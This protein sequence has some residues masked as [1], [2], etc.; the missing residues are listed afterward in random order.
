M[1]LSGKDRLRILQNAIA[2]V[3]SIDKVD[4]ATELAKSVSM[5]N[6]FNAQQQ[7][8]QFGSDMAMNAPQATGGMIS[9]DASQG[10]TEEQTALNGMNLP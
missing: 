7:L 2:R 10:M 5:V 1:N 8:S 9:P 4:L 6:G 3:G